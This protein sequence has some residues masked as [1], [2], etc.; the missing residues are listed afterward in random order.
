MYLSK[1]KL[2]EEYE[3]SKSSVDRILKLIRDH[4]AR[5][6]K[7][8]VIRSGNIVRIRDDVF[9]DAFQYTDQILCGVAPKFVPNERHAWERISAL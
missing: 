5:Y 1:A 6:P 3:I 2:M 8:A 7:S 9:L 4:S